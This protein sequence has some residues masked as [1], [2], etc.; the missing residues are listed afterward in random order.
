MPQ[1]FSTADLF[2]AHPDLLQTCDVQFR[3]FGKHMCFSGD[4]VTVAVFEDHRPVLEILETKGEGRVLVVDGKGSLRVGVLGDRLAD[5]AANNG[6]AGIVINGAVRDSSGID[7]LEIGV[8]ALGT[9][10]RRGPAPN[11]SSSGIP[12]VI[13]G[14]TVISGNWIYA[15]RDCVIVAP[16]ALNIA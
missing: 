15:D 4:C 2:D 12:V 3:S 13:G 10:A 1:A 11:P 16:H 7:A 5:I 8:K 9:T 6:W 14:A